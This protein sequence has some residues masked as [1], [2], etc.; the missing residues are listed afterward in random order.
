VEAFLTSIRKKVY[1]GRLPATGDD[2]KGG[3]GDERGAR[4]IVLRKTMRLPL[5]ALRVVLSID[6]VER[7]SR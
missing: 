1:T 5:P 7:W 2:P 6:G 3:G 4:V